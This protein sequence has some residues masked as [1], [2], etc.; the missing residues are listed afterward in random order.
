MTKNSNNGP[1]CSK[2]V[3]EDPT[4]ADIVEDFVA[5]LD[6]R[7]QAL[8]EAFATHDFENLRSLSHQLK[9]AGGGHGYQILTELAAV[10][11]KQAVAEQIDACEQSLAE[12]TSIIGRVEVGADPVE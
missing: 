8:Q 9:G 2:L 3:E 5:G 1:I 4:F 6:G 10:L 12:L 11:E 7:L